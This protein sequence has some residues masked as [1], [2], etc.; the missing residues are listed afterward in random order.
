MPKVHIYPLSRLVHA[1]AANW[2]RLLKSIED[3]KTHAFAYYRPMREAVVM[4]CQKQGKGRDR[5]VSGLMLRAMQYG[6]RRGKEVAK[7]NLKAFEV[8]EEAFYPRLGKFR[9][10]FLREQQAG[11]KFSGLTI[12]GAPHFETEDSE[13]RDR[14]VLLVPGEWSQ[15]D[16]KAYLELLAIILEACYG[17]GSE[18]LW[19]FDLKNCKE[20]K[21]KSSP[22]IRKRCE[23]AAK[24]YGRLIQLLEE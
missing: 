22:R 19:I 16:L 15:D 5:I 13:G 7:N 21:W 8:F 3:G 9:R 17:A 12:L 10:H 1:P 11:C 24:L 14:Y 2:E 18:D 6:G 20:I 23:N 4:Y